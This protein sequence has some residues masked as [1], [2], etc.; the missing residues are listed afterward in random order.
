MIQ[1]LKLLMQGGEVNPQPKAL[2]IQA[3]LGKDGNLTAENLRILTAIKP[4]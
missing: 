4:Q 1:G 3:L 2:D